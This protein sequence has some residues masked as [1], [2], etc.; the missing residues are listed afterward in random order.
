MV[1]PFVKAF[2]S[3]LILDDDLGFVFWLGEAL[4][5]AGYEAVPAVGVPDAKG[6]TGTFHFTP[7]LVIANPT[8]A[9]VAEFTRALRQGPRPAAVIEITTATGEAK[10]GLRADGFQPRPDVADDRAKLAWLRTIRE[11]LRESATG[12]LRRAG[13]RMRSGLPAVSVR[14]R[15]E[16]CDRSMAAARVRRDR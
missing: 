16:E 9:G 8:L 1:L 6:R 2:Q 5:S 14:S 3:V 12:R 15:A 10:I 4:V 13:R 11:V 7:D